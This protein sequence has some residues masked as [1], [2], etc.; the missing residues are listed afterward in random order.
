LEYRRQENLRK[1][2]KK[3]DLAKKDVEELEEEN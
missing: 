3:C 2:E 1:D